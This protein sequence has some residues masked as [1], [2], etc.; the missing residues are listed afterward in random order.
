[1]NKQTL[2]VVPLKIGPVSIDPPVLLAP[3]AGYTDA[4][5]RSVCKRFHCGA[6]FTEMVNAAGIVHGSRRTLHLLETAPGE[7]PV[8]AHLYAREP[9]PL[10][11]AAAIVEKLGKFDFIDINCGCPV[12]KIVA[13]GAGVAL[14]KNPETIQAMVRAVRAAVSLPVTIKTRLGLSPDKM[15]I[16]EVARGAQ[17]GGASALFLHARFASNRHTG[18]PDWEALARIKSELAIPV[19]G[20]GGISSATDVPRMLRE[21]GVDG[22]MIGRAAVGHPWIFGEIYALLAGLSFAPPSPE[23]RRAIIA[24]HFER[25]VELKTKE[26]KYR[27]RARLPADQGAAAHFKSHLFRYLSGPE[28]R[29]LFGE[30]K[31]EFWVRAARGEL[32]PA[33]ESP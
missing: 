14:M 16:S 29:R 11:E 9:G 4:A 24:E 31:P 15:N 20:N 2:Q 12:R 19:I 25:L 1:M 23:E 10:A 17:E 26:L 8:A 7:R 28:R 5:F 33:A 27:K 13:K 18:A 6:V 30:H 22:V 32:P 3:M 21:T